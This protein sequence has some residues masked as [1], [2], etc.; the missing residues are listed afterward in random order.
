MKNVN[1]LGVHWKIWHLVGFTKNQYRGG[2]CL[3]IGAWTVYQFKG[4]GLGKKAE[5]GI[6]EGLVDIPMHTM[7]NLHMGKH[8]TMKKFFR[9]LMKFSSYFYGYYYYHYYANM[10]IVNE[11]V[12]LHI[13][14]LLF[15]FSKKVCLESFISCKFYLYSD[16][17]TLSI[18]IL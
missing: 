6:L 18:C 10:N 12:Q 3:K 8:I 13:V 15:W 17:T 5:S 1:I 4:G 11:H 2:D 9:V 14:N 16:L 7:K